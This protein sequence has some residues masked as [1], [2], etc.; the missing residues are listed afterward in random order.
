MVDQPTANLGEPIQPRRLTWAI[1][2]ATW[3]EFARSAL[4]LPDDADGRRMRDSVNDIIM[5]QAVWF[6]LGDLGEL[7]ADERALGLDRAGV[8]IEKHGGAL[9]AR[10]GGDMPEL[11]AEM[12][13]DAAD[14]LELVAAGRS[15][16]G[17]DAPDSISPAD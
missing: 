15:L 11:L 9:E 4:S 16:D 7:D 14:R 8:L 1:M 5:L 12:I 13:Q 6:A 17:N 2:L 10:W 3:V